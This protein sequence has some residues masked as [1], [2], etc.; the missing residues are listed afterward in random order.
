MILLSRHRRAR[1]GGVECKMELL[2]QVR[3][4]AI[5]KEIPVYQLAHPDRVIV[6]R[7][8]LKASLIAT[9]SKTTANQLPRENKV[10]RLLQSNHQPP[11]STSTSLQ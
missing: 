1:R 9:H 6:N 11:P 4:G 10:V 5:L 2:V 8:Q 3:I 7:H